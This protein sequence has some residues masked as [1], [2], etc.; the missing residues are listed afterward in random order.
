MSKKYSY[1]ALLIVLSSFLL[2]LYLIFTLAFRPPS[3]PQSNDQQEYAAYGYRIASGENYYDFGMRPPL[4]PYVL[5]NVLKITTDL[6]VMRVL[7]VIGQLALSLVMFFVVSRILGLR[8]GLVSLGLLAFYPGLIYGNLVLLSDSLFNTLI[9]FSFLLG[10]SLLFALKRGFSRSWII[11]WACLLGL[12]SGLGYMTRSAAIFIPIA[13]GLTLLVS[14]LKHRFIAVLAM[15]VVLVATISPMLWNTHQARGYWGST[16]NYFW[17][18]LYDGNNSSDNVIFVWKG[19]SGDP[20][21]WNSIQSCKDP[22]RPYVSFS[23][24][25]GNLKRALIEQIKQRPLLAFM[26]LFGKAIDMWGPERSFA[27]DVLDGDFGP[28]SYQWMIFV[29]LTANVFYVIALLGGSIGMWAERQQREIVW[30][31]ALILLLTTAG[32]SLIAYGHPRYH[33]PLMSIFILFSGPG[34]FV[35]FEKISRYIKRP[36]IISHRSLEAEK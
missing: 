11:L 20:V 4:Y 26:R 17:I 10:I 28:A 30:F 5:G 6:R 15:M 7:Q 3:S 19:I 35:L 9:G 33:K 23:D 21:I 29:A 18:T 22:Q 1:V 25:T 16:E 27:G 36:N 34:L 2:Q 8:Y 32:I 24:C 14:K 31:A 12:V 13:M